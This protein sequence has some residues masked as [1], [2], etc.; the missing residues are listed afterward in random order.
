MAT[1]STRSSSAPAPRAVSRA[2]AS[3]AVV[4]NLAPPGPSLSLTPRPSSGCRS[5]SS[6]PSP[7]KFLPQPATMHT[8]NCRPLDLWMLMMFTAS[9]PVG[10]SSAACKSVPESLSRSKNRTKPDSP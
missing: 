1:Y 4:V 3:R 10:C 6:A 5:T 2:M 7:A 8:G 9:E